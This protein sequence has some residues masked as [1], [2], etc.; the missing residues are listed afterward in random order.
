MRV[1]RRSLLIWVAL[2]I[3]GF[4]PISDLED[5]YYLQA[6]VNDDTYTFDD[7]TLKVFRFTR[8]KGKFMFEVVGPLEMTAKGQRPLT[9]YMQ[10]VRHDLVGP[11]TIALTQ[12]RFVNSQSKVF[13]RTDQQG[14]AG[15]LMI[16]KINDK[17]VEGAFY[18]VL[19]AKDSAIT[20]IKG[21]FRAKHSVM[22]H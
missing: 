9:L 21:K 12:G 17:S 22:R 2:L 10:S 18:M 20:R 11:D 19:D 16:Q 15:R 1:N 8:T 14:G 4:K 13:S 6:T 5:N 7:A 3:G